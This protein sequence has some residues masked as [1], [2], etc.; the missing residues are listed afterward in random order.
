L[1]EE[2]RNQAE[3][4]HIEIR[5]QIE[6]E[7]FLDARGGLVRAEQ[8]GTDNLRIILLSCIKGSL[9]FCLPSFFLPSFCLLCFQ[10]FII[11]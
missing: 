8:Q 2:I 5:V 9:G 1:T 3:G 6:E 7:Q 10:S 4:E 11:T